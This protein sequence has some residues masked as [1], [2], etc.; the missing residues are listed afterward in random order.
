LNRRKRVDKEQN[1][2]AKTMN[3]K[4]Q[5]VN[6]KVEVFKKEKEQNKVVHNEKLRLKSE[7][8]EKLREQNARVQAMKKT[9]FLRKKLQA[10]DNMQ[11]RKMNQEIITNQ[12]K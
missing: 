9:E 11:K 5:K 2:K 7:D 4:I 12:V 8:L 6:D 10:E 1:E 3:M